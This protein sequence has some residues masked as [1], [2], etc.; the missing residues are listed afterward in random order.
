MEPRRM[1]IT[2]PLRGQAVMPARQSF[3]CE[4]AEYRGCQ[5]VFRWALCIAR[6]VLS[7]Q[8]IDSGGVGRL[9]PFA[10]CDARWSHL[11]TGRTFTRA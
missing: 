10:F 7:R 4:A 8:A 11:A 9:Q 5:R 6:R 2:R 1:T 3:A